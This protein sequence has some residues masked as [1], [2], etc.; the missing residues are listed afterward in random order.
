MSVSTTHLLILLAVG[1]ISL[2]ILGFVKSSGSLSVRAID[3]SLAATDT[4]TTYDLGVLV[5]KYF[6]LTSDGQNIDIVVTGDVGG[7]YQTV[8]QHTSSVTTNLFSMLPQA[9]KYLGYSN[10]SAQ[11]SLNYSLVDTK[12]YTQAVPMLTDG[13]RRPNYNQ[14]MQ[15]HTICNY[16]DNQNVR[17]VWLW[18]YQGPSYPGSSEPYLSISES[19]MAGPFGDISNSYRLNDMPTCNNTYRVYTFNYGRGTSEAVHSWG[20]QIEAEMAAVDNGVFRTLW[21]GPAYPQTQGVNGRC[22]SVHNPPNARSEYDWVNPTPQKSDCMDWTP[23]GMGTLSDISCSIWG[24]QDISD[25][26]N[27]SLNYQIWNWQNMPGRNNT[28]SYQGR[29]MRNWW[30]VHGD[31]DA[32]MGGDRTLYITVPASYTPVVTDSFDRADSTT[33]LGVSDSAHPWILAKGTW[34]IVNNQAY[35]AT[36]CPA[37]GYALIDSGSKDGYVE[38]TAA[39]NRQDMRIPFRYVDANNMYVL[40]NRGS[41]Y[42][43]TKFVNGER[44]GVGASSGVTPAD[45]DVIKIEMNGAEIKVYVNNVVRITTSDTSLSGTQHGLGNWCSGVLRFDN[46]TIARLNPA[47][48]PVPTV[49]ASA[50]VIPHITPTP[51]ATAIP[52]VVPTATPVVTATP[53]PTVVPT[54]TPTVVPT[55]TPTPRPTVTPTPVPNI[56]RIQGRVTSTNGNSIG[57]A[58]IEITASGFRQIYFANSRGEYSISNLPAG[59]T[60]TLK[61]SAFL[62]YSASRT[63]TVTRGTTVTQ[64]VTLRRIF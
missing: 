34:G 3:D 18:A 7:S 33:S 10:S 36:G 49:V 31:F 41:L 43:V 16:V 15:Q 39:V 5:I 23:D 46:F 44:I 25:S 61:Y 48:T 13:S 60:Y 8:R 40:E 38:V 24:C 62:Y 47:A 21:Q 30:D 56:G 11:P 32:V 64:N 20:H 51:T 45:G 19:K 53:Q 59:R 22:G 58:R 6:P 63:V 1:M 52:T 42:D 12:E 54:K 26:N 29:A 35:S 28:K 37:P 50:S 17:E 57:G 9:T 27:S 2:L 14:I 4:N 55:R